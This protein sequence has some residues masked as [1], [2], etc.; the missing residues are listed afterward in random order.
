MEN[1]A[2]L[3]SA[4]ASL[5]W[6]ALVAIFAFKFL[7]PLKGLIESFRGR[8]FTI[9]VGDN[10]LS[11]EEAS[12]QQRIITADIQSKLAELERR[13]ASG[14]PVILSEPPLSTIT[15]RRILW[16]DDSPRNNS[17]LVATLQE[18]GHEVDIALTTTAGISQFRAHTYD[19]VIS[20][21]GRPES[22]KAGIDLVEKIRKYNSDVPVFIYCGSWASKNMRQEALSAGATEITSSG[23]TLL[24]L[25]PLE[26]TS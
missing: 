26:S 7:E 6:P 21:M 17:F 14:Q 3:T 24:S 22:D 15:R 18:R 13:L 4:L 5:A 1:V 9:K 12:E 8:K 11:V 25:L 10:E 19:A 20:D 23:T 2:E 16:V